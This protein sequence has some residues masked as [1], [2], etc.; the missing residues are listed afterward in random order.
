MN[1]IDITNLDSNKYSFDKN[2]FFATPKTDIKD[3][4][5]VE[6]GDSKQT[7][8]FPQTKVMRWDNEVNVSV[9]LIHDEVSPTIT[10]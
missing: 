8:F 3:K 10:T 5:Q 2:T 7:D 9:R 1:E 6:I 4:I